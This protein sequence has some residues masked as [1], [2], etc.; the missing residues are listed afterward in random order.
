MSSPRHEI[1]QI[2]TESWLPN[3]DAERFAGYAVMGLPFASGHVLALRRYPASSI[4]PG[5]TSVWHR[6]PAGHWTFYSDVDPPLACCRYF[7]DPLARPQQTEIAL[8]WVGAWSLAVELPDV[9]LIW[10]LRLAET[11]ATRCM[12]ATWSALPSW[13]W[14]RPS[15]VG[16]MGRFAGLILGAG[17][18]GLTGRTPNRQRFLEMP[19]SVW[20]V[21]H[22]VASIGGVDLGVPAPLSVQDRLGDFAIP[23]RGLYV[24]GR[25]FFEPFDDAIHLTCTANSLRDTSGVPAPVGLV[26]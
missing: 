9:E 15:L 3:G 23:Q 24:I 5:Y 13:V 6:D 19:R 10:H 11:V 1:W 12:S 25:S 17:K 18:L 20:A 21:S 8:R 4:G 16:T 22:S 2:E 7:G 26:A 14:G